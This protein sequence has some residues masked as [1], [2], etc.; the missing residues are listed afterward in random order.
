MPIEQ[1]IFLNTAHDHI[2]LLLVLVNIGNS[3][4]TKTYSLMYLRIQIIAFIKRFDSVGC[5]LLAVIL[6]RIDIWLWKGVPGGNSRTCWTRL[7]LTFKWSTPFRRQM[8]I[9]EPTSRIMPPTSFEW[10]FE[11]CSIRS[12]YDTAISKSI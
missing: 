9:R 5:I 6:P 2:R 12:D 8:P 1:Q 7:Y 3:D 10:S 11:T 4:C